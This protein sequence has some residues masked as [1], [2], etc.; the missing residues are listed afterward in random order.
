M[1]GPRVLFLIRHG[2]SDETSNELVQTHRG[3]QWDPP[4]DEVGREQAEL[5][6]RRLA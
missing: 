4:L 5:L 6:A 2:R 1:S 3:P